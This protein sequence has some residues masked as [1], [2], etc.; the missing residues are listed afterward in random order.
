MQRIGVLRGG[1][2]D[3]YSL[4]LKSGARI[5]EALRAEG[6]D[7]VDMFIDREGI[8]HIK[9]IP[10]D[11][12]HAAHQVDLVW[13]TLHG[14]G[15]EDGQIQAMLESAGVPYTG[16]EVLASRMASNKLI[17][18]DRARELGIKTP[19]AILVMPEGGESVS[20]I[21]QAIYRRMA[22]P[23]VVKPLVGGASVHTY[24]AFTPL[25]LAQFIEESISHGQP[26]IIEQYI[27][28][29]EASVSV[30][31]D[32]RGKNRYV[33]PVVEIK[34]AA[35]GILTHEGIQSD[36]HAVVGGGFR[37]DERERLS[38][39]ARDMHVHLG[40]RDFSQSGFIV[41]KQGKIWY[42]ETDTLPH[43]HEQ[44][45]FAKALASVGSS[46]SEFIHSIIGRKK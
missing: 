13:N 25:E 16:S 29:R 4:S 34:S 38:A 17:A 14:E 10:I 32:F 28:G 33:L 22:P 9:G 5:M 3:E 43:M 6:Y 26:F 46:M 42:L 21:T 7:V 15:G 23:W 24:F 36:E 30:I 18:K 8:L 41:D 45:A 2:S 20:E 12:E 19:E 11:L 31:D 1:V 39:L 37:S 35:Q 27:Y 40:A 44:G